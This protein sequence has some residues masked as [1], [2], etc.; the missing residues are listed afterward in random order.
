MTPLLEATD[1]CVT[2][3][4]LRAVDGLSFSLQEGEIVGLIGPNGAGKSTLVGV[5]SGAT[6]QWTGDVTLEGV[7]I[8]ERRPSQV[9][10]MGISRTFQ[11]AQPFTT[12]TVL[13]NV[14][15]GA[16]YG[17]AT[18]ASMR[19]ARGEALE[20]VRALG[21]E[22]KA[23]LPAESLN[24]PERKRLEM[25]K[26]LATR[27]KVLLLDEVLAGLTVTEIELA[28]PL[29][30]RV[31]ERGVAVLLI[32]HV[33]Q[34]IELLADRVVFLHHGRKVLDDRPDVVFADP[35]LT[36]AYLGSA[37]TVRDERSR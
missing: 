19:Q 31:R 17:T 34:A 4:R 13:E 2:F 24:A 3:G 35:R 6:S 32:E 12:M 9:T 21:L 16:L 23:S 28:V 14:M 1:V 8:R 20:L 22:D 11:V 29:I 36:E 30:R 33:M 10:R 37:G 27:P 26:A 18:R 5:L 7:S 25:A 15:V